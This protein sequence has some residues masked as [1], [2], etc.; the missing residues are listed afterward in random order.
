MRPN[1]ERQYAVISAMIPEFSP[2]WNASA[3][4]L[5]VFDIHRFTLFNTETGIPLARRRKI[6]RLARDLLSELDGLGGLR[7]ETLGDLRDLAA[8]AP[9][10][11]MRDRRL[12]QFSVT[13]SV[14]RMAVRLYIEACD[15]PGFSMNGPLHRFANAVGELVLSERAPF[16]NDSVRAEFKSMRRV[17][18]KP[19]RRLSDFY[20]P[21][22][23]GV[24]ERKTQDT[25]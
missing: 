3:V 6:S 11:S 4:A 7:L 15:R 8:G 10:R 21:D 2:G 25:I 22:A 1:V 16:S 20:A 12:G 18:R 19:V 5:R 14:R 9:A 17:V 13:D 24:A 23:S